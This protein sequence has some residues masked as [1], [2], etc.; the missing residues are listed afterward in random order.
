MD[1]AVTRKLGIAPG[2]FVLLIG[3]PPGVLE[4]L[5]ELPQGASFTV[6]PAL[7]HPLIL[8]FVSSKA[9]VDRLAPRA[10]RHLSQSGTIWFVYPRNGNTDLSPTLGWNALYARGFRPVTQIAFGPCWT[11]FCFRPTALMPKHPVMRAAGREPQAGQLHAGEMNAL[12]KDP[13][14]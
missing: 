13:N 1:P 8:A 10:V 6:H 5:G 7:A 4:S 9:D 12:S 14:L 2:M 3:P 11:A